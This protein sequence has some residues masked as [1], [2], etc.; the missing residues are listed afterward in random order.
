MYVLAHKGN[1]E[2]NTTIQIIINNSVIKSLTLYH[3][4]YI[5]VYIYTDD[6]ICLNG[7]AL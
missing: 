2:A 3:G 4:A 5:Y 1:T 7:K 6:I